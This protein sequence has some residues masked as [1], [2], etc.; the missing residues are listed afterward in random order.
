M[1][2]WWFLSYRW[3]MWF[4]YFRVLPTPMLNSPRS[5]RSPSP[6]VPMRPQP[7]VIPRS[8]VSLLKV[9]HQWTPPPTSQS[10]A[11]SPTAPHCRRTWTSQDRLRSRN[12]SLTRCCL[13]S[14]DHRKKPEIWISSGF[15]YVWTLMWTEGWTMKEFH[16]IL[17]AW[18]HATATVII[19]LGLL[20]GFFYDV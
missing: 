4:P 1:L 3:K 2:L 19:L 10:S 12:T 14:E 13:S 7:Q 18:S 6:T 20:L 11:G 17:L 5:L 8:W 9:K 15:S 16:F